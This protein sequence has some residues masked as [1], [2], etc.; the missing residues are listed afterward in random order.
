MP[1]RALL[2]VYNK[3]GI[4]EFGRGL[5]DLGYEVISTGGTRLPV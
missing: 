5:V 1:K 3:T 2:S 4:A